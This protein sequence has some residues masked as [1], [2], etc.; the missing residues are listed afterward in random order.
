MIAAVQAGVEVGA[1]WREPAWLLFGAV[2]AG[3]L[4]LVR[5]A[6]L[7]AASVPATVPSGASPLP[8][9]LRTV[10]VS[11]PTV[12]EAAALV[13]FGAAL[14]RPVLVESE[15]PARLGR[16]VLLCLD[17]SSSMATEDLAP[18]RSRLAVAREVGAEFLLGR[19]DDRVGLV[20]F[21]R[22]ADLVCA[23]TVDR[24]AAGELLDAIRLVD[25]EGPEDA[26][27]IGA[28]NL[29]TFGADGIT[30][31]NTD[32]RGFLAALEPAGIPYAQSTALV[33]GA[34]G[35][36]RALVHALVASGISRLIL[37]NRT[38]A[39][40]EALAGALAPKARIVEWADRN[41]ALSEA[42]LVVNA[43]AL[44]LKGQSE[45]DMDW[46]RARPGAVV[47]DSVYTPLMT[48]FLRGASRAGLTV[49]DGLDM[50][51]GQA[52]P[53][54][55]AFFGVPAPSGPPVRPV[56]LEALGETS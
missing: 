32:A 45:L 56:L 35:A 34:G 51:I 33:L 54:F 44:G 1:Q 16:D 31:D 47:F 12:L 29:L 37:T 18:G 40:A 28:A 3:V 39:R 14:A 22:F 30:A 11:L 52:V 48:G 36:S 23:P 43:T 21:A 27:A 8:R 5:R 25:A 50:L 4:L 7:R 55:Q 10:L 24:V 38:R 9:T 41:D 46:I 53:S 15:P 26:T 2:C 17:R 42:D 6:R 13:A 20:S 19:T 49:V